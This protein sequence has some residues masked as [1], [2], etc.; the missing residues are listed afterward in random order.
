M[1]KA[2]NACAQTG[3]D[4]GPKPPDLARWT[5]DGWK[6]LLRARFLEELDNL[7][8]PSSDNIKQLSERYLGFDLTSRWSW[9]GCSASKA[10][11]RLNALI[12]LRGS[13]VHR[14]KEAFAGAAVKLDE[15]R[16]GVDLVRR[17][18]K[19]TDKALPVER[20]T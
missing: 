3:L 16:D 4:A 17:L 5:G 10:A 11:R 14:G 7:H 20:G 13:L 19:L 2:F 12:K 9:P 15:V 8:T 6:E 1:R 18:V